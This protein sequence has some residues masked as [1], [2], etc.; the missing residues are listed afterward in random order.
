MR[1]SSEQASARPFTTEPQSAPLQSGPSLTLTK[2]LQWRLPM[3]SQTEL[4]ADA[5]GGGPLN[6]NTSIPSGS[7]WDPVLQVGRTYLERG[8]DPL[9]IA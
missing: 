5:D 4:M 8:C 1:F 3:N 6:P 9:K 7:A 2:H